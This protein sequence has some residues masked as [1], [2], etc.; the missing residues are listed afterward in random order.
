MALSLVSLN[1]EEDKRFDTALPFF[2]DIRPDVT[3]VQEL[4]EH[5]IP[6]F[7]AVCGP[8]AAFAP[9]CRVVR[10][11]EEYVRGTALF[12]RR[13]V[14][15]AG[16]HYYVG[17]KETIRVDDGISDVG[18]HAVVYADVGEE[19][20]RILTTHHTWSMDGAS[21]PEQLTDVDSLM[22]FLEGLDGFVLCGDFNAPRGGETFSRLAAHYTDNIPQEYKTS[23]DTALH[24]TRDRPE[25][26]ARV[27]T[28]MV[29]GLFTTPAY[30]ARDVRFQFGVSDHAA[31]VATLEKTATL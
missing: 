26:R 15:N 1:V 8:L 5:D 30:V 21:T 28:F 4:L 10:N 27:E 22:A 2:A 16:V 31:I 24:K 11:G 6:R 13:N 3:C 9:L 12:S 19:S 29:D 23:I 7:E 25:A 17:A 14:A 18:T 20:Y